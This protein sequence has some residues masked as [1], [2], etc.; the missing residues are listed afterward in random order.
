MRFRK[1]FRTTGLIF[2][3]RNR[4]AAVVQVRFIQ[5]EAKYLAVAAPHPCHDAFRESSL[6]ANGASPK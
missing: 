5:A 1:P 2:T 6:S 3:S 4:P